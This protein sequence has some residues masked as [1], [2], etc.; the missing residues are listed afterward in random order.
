VIE[1][2]DRTSWT[3]VPSPNPNPQGNNGLGAVAVVS[4]NDVW[5]VGE[6][7]LGPFTEHWDGTS[8]RIVATPGG[9]NFLAGMAAASGPCS[10]SARAPTAAA[11]SCRTDPA[12]ASG[13]PSSVA[14][15]A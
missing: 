2:W 12:F 7:P 9:V 5:A 11:S 15:G 6:Q 14:D 10:P 13:R 4:A 3:V 8:W 1:H